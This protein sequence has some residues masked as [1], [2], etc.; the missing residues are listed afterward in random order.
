MARKNAEAA[1]FQARKDQHV[2]SSPTAEASDPI[3]ARITRA[4][5]AVRVWRV[6]R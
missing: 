5:A 6:Q 3:G 4:V 1:D 2:H